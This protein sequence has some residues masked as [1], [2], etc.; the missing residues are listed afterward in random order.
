MELRV[1]T[2]DLFKQLSRFKLLQTVGV[3]LLVLEA[4]LRNH[5]LRYY[6]RD[7]NSMYLEWKADQERLK[8]CKPTTNTPITA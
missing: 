7:W 2:I 3:E 1:E 5:C 8:C 4:S 6:Q